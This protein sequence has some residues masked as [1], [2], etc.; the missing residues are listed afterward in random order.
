MYNKL[1]IFFSKGKT[2]MKKYLSSILLVLLMMSVF[3]FQPNKAMAVEDVEF[4][5]YYQTIEEVV[6]INE[7]VDKD[8][9]LWDKA[10]HLGKSVV[11]WA[12]KT[13][14]NGITR[15]IT[16]GEGE[17][18]WYSK[19]N[20]N[21]A[22]KVKR[23]K[24][25][26]EEELIK[27]MGKTSED[28]LTYGQKCLLSSFRA[29]NSDA[30]ESREDAS[31]RKKIKLILTDT[32]DY[33]TTRDDKDPNV[34][35]DFWPYSSGP[36]ISMSDAMYKYNENSVPSGIESAYS[37]VIHEYSHSMDRTYALQL[38]PYGQDGIHYSDEVTT[39]RMAFIEGWAEY[40]E[41]LESE[42]K[43]N[44]YKNAMNKLSIE[45]KKKG[46][47]GE[48]S[49]LDPASATFKQLL[50]AEA[51]NCNTLYRLSQELDDGP[52]KITKAFTSTR[53]NI[54]RDLNTI[55][56]KLVKQNP[57][58]T[59]KI[60]KIVDEMFLGKMTEEEFYKMV[61]KTDK[62]KAYFESREANKAE[63]TSEEAVEVETTED[64]DVSKEKITV[65]NE[66]GNPFEDK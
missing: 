2:K 17:S 46:E 9:S 8:A 62:T 47:S 1:V 27:A 52:A 14:E 30:I 6:T 5:I 10:K 20:P 41:M 49:D 55:V 33:A 12:K 45:S 15:N 13:W 53:W 61:G 4:G 42:T 63:E 32:G 66:S 29:A 58:D 50:S 36:T 25:T 7:D 38:K 21:I 64:V 44:S 39:P 56:K 43:A 19:T 23:T 34:R 18:L 24:V 51:Y 54:F 65:E 11:N 3:C 31:Y 48:Y 22:Y 28:E 37:T 26:T 57:D 60:C 59:E 40:N 16:L 35:E